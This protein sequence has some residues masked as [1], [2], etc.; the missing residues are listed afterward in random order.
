LKNV[1]ASNRDDCGQRQGFLE[2]PI[3]VTESLPGV[4][5]LMATVE[6]NFSRDQRNSRLGKELWKG[7]ESIRVPTIRKMSGHHV[8]TDAD[9]PSE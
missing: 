8:E 3:N 1:S 7:M 2:V 5:A 9:H 4:T 6:I